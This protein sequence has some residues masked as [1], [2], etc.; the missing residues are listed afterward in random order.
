MTVRML[1]YWNGYSPDAIVTGLSN[2]AALIAAGYA[3]ADLDG[4][5]NGLIDDAKLRTTA[6]G[7]VSL[8]G[9]NNRKIRAI[10]D[11]S[12]PVLLIGGD[13]P[14][15]Q[16]WGTNGAD[17]MAA[18]YAA[19][20]VKPY[21]AINTGPLN[22]ATEDPVDFMTS[23][24]IRSLSGKVELIAHGHRHPQDWRLVNTGIVIR[25]TG[26][27]ASGTVT[28]TSTTVSGTTTGA[29]DDFSFN[30]TTA[31]YDT[32]AELVAAIDALANWTCT[33]APELLGTE[34]S[35]NLMAR[36]AADAKTANLYLCAGGGILITNTGTTYRRLTAGFS[37]GTLSLFADGVQ[38]YSASITATT[39]SA[40]VTAINALGGGIT[41]ELTN[42]RERNLNNYCSGSESGAAITASWS[43]SRHVGID[44]LYIHGGLSHWYI[45]DRQFKACVAAAAA[46]GITLKDFAQPGDRFHP[47]EMD[48]HSSFRLHR[49]NKN[50]G[51]SI[52]PNAFMRGS[53]FVHHKAASQIFYPTPSAARLNAVLAA[54]EDSPGYCVNLL[55]HNLLADGTSGY[56]FPTNHPA[57]YDQ[58][59]ADWIAFLSVAK[60]SQDA[61]RIAI[62]S[63]EDYY[64]AVPPNQAKL[65]NLLFNPR[66]RN[67]AESLLVA[68]SDPGKIVPGWRLGT[69]SANCSAAS[70]DSDGFLSVTVSSGSPAPLQ[71][72]VNLPPGLYEYRAQVPA[73]AY[74]SGEGLN[75]NVTSYSPDYFALLADNPVPGK[76][77]FSTIN[78]LRGPG[79]LSIRFAVSPPKPSPAQAISKNSQTWNL[80]T[81]KN[82]RIN[83]NGIGLTADIDCSAGASS[84]SAVTAKE[85]AAA[86]NAAIAANASYGA[87]YHTCAR[88]AAGKVIIT[89]PYVGSDRTHN[90]TVSDGTTAS[91]MTTIFGGGVEA[92]PMLADHSMFGGAP[93]TLGVNANLVGTAKIGAFS[94]RRIGDYA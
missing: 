24:Q 52:A 2:E 33:L 18:L 12:T 4:A 61:G 44:G 34:A 84:A 63:Q 6:D 89:S 40:V 46:N 93:I 64:R 67:S 62:L 5:N 88:A 71:Q 8:V 25:Y 83:I 1:Q 32:L 53:N 41:A 72:V 26:A 55:M 17:G 27:A 94:L 57:N 51:A 16:W 19:M 77:T 87:E 9:P 78:A 90:V 58:V 60:A 36:A 47:P 3:T 31:N 7:S 81:N 28:V 82:I 54:L 43:G 20:G 74:T 69:L 15:Q 22:T 85:V 79:E 11:P 35:T 73:L 37:G 14:Y 59:E 65:G 92:Y 68:A 70:I 45:V 91:A 49:G 30:I 29:V 38:I 56:S 50:V 75:L 10:Y 48:G 42:D 23:D 39:L 80:S 66:L 86:I 13:H 21:L 76:T